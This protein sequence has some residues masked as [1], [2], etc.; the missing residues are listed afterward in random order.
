MED[1]IKFIALGGLDEPGK[2]CYIIEINN[3]IFVLECGLSLPDKTIPGVDFVLANAD[4]LIQNKDRI[5]AYIITH[6]HDENCG[7][8]QYFYPKAEAP[9][10]CSNSTRIILEAEAKRFG[11]KPHFKFEIV[12]PSESKIIKGRTVHFFQTSHNAS[13]SFGVAI[14]TSKGNI[15]Y[16]GDFIIDFNAKEKGYYFDLKYQKL[17]FDFQM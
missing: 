17:S 1:N 4:Y 3:D 9:I 5:A 11:L 6:G 7:G 14:N 8:L 2:D 12:Q 15:V 13:Y 16:T 10:Y